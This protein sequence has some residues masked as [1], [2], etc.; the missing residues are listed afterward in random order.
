MPARFRRAIPWLLAA[1]TGLLL[2]LASPGSGDQSWLAFLALVPLL[3]AVDGVSPRRAFALGFAAS[4]VLWTITLAWPAPWVTH[5]GGIGWGRG[6]LTGAVILVLVSVFMAAFA[7]VAASAHHR[8]GVDAV[9]IVASAWVA[10]E[11]LR[12]TVTGFP[13]NLLAASQWR[14]TE[15]IQVATITGVYGV[16]FVVAA[17]NVAVA[18]V[19]RHDRPAG[20]AAGALGTAALILVFSMMASW[21]VPAA[22]TRGTAVPV[23][24]VQGNIDQSVK[25]DRGYIDSALDVH[26]ALTRQAVESGARFVVWPETAVPLHDRTDPRW[27]AVERVAR[28]AGIHLLVGAPHGP[29]EAPRNSA[30]LISPDG[31]VARYDKRQLLPFA[32]YVPWRGALSFL[33][34]VTGDAISEFAAGADTVVFQT[35]FG[36][37]ATVICYEAILPAET[38]EL[39]LAGADVLVNLTNDAWFGPTPTPVQHLAL[40]TFR[41]VEHR[42]WLVRAANSGISAIIAPDGRIVESSALFTRGVLT[43][44]FTRRTTPTFYTR[45]GDLFAWTTVGVS[46]AALLPLPLRRRRPVEVTAG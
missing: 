2:T 35:P 12:A 9:V 27:A 13:W 8:F 42:A 26:H 40:A 3:V 24:I 39:F 28:D 25:W 34:V 46:A 21:L 6:A 43:G 18:R 16:S 41:A 37:L 20:D 30:F 10:L 11:F 36:R 22:S 38:R 45:Y 31:S 15:L 33:T 19:L 7:V 32:E 1:A 23:A 29:R 14:Q 5:Y 4:A 17:V 44:T